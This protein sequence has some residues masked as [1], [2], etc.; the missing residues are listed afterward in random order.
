METIP[1]P[2]K[3]TKEDSI[4][5]IENELLLPGLPNHL[6][7]IC[8]SF[9]SPALLFS[10]CHAWRR[11]LY[12]HSFP[13]FF[14]LYVLVSPPPNRKVDQVDAINSI[15]FLSLDPFSSK[16]QSL[17]SPPKDPPLHLLHRHPSFLSRNLSIQSLTVSNHLVL[18]AGT[19]CRFVPALSMPLLF[20]PESNYWFFGPPFTIP[21]RWCATGSV[22]G[23]IYL[24]S[25]VASH[26]SGDV[27]RSMER[28][29]TKQ[30]KENWRWEKMAP[31][32]DGRFS[33]EAI[34]AVGCKGK[35]Y[36]VNVKG[37]AVKDGCVYNVDANLW[38][39]MPK[40]ML[41]GWN[42]PA[43]PMDE[44]V[45]YVV[46]EVKGALSEYDSERD[47]WK[48][49]IE[50][51]ELK[52]AEQIAAGRG[53]VCVVCGNGEKIVVVDVM[54]TPAR[55]WVVEPPPGQQVVS[56]HILPRMSKRA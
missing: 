3:E 14:S 50:L 30:K 33:R 45:I 44:E 37:N 55:V 53:R 32:K 5:D 21:R 27:A 18:M 52:M 35:L 6:A 25:G 2:S 51:P 19:T 41:A 16:W 1:K 49:V 56:V 28:W 9:L 43:V 8:L 48:K 7:Q 54:A 46:D 40:G 31:L 36:M 11:L 42:G 12:S 17:P 38:E 39:N 15:Q 47:C 34:E 26:Y 20:H 24:A 29:D 13:P 22:G 10:V 23:T 4:D